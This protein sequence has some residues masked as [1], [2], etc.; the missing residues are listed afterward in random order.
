[1]DPGRV[2]ED[3]EAAL[4]FN[5]IQPLLFDG[6]R[7]T[8]SLA[9]WLYDMELIYRVC[10]IEA[11]L[12][13]SLASRRLAGDAR[14]WWMTLGE[15]AMPGG[16]WVDFHALIIARYGPLP[17]EEANMP[18]R[19]PEIYNDMYLG[20]YL[21]YVADWRA[22]PNES[23]GHY[24]RRF[25]DAMLPYIPQDLGSPEL[26][27]LHPLRGG[28]P[29]EV[30]IFV[31]APMVGMTLE[32][33]INDIMEAE[34]ITHMLQVNAVVDDYQVLVDDA[35]IGEPLFHGGPL[36]PENPIP[37]VPLQE[38]PPQEAEAG[39]DADD[40]DP[41]DFPNNPE[42]NLKDPPVIIIESDDEE[43]VEE[44]FV[45]EWEEFEGVEVDIE[46]VEDDPEEI[47]FGDEDWDIFSDVMT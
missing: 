34:I 46:D 19:D 12:Q 30:R 28:L 18:Y 25:Q 41:A 3:H 20:R 4:V 17:D 8:V 26:Q 22:Y 21:S 29:P 47:L 33:M 15:R 38:I 6:T 35:G 23:M 45:E 1:M 42:E 44:E 40:I 27:A 39:A 16:S 32:N 37:T 13:V 11:R 36:L 24:C 7:R 31:L 9:G 2:D 10:H 14:L 43:D 5:G